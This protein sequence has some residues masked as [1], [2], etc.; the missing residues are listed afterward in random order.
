MRNTRAVDEINL[1]E[2]E[3]DVGPVLLLADDTVIT[4]IIRARGTWEE[5]LGDQIRRCCAPA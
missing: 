2:V 5:E 3:T 4:P 1:E